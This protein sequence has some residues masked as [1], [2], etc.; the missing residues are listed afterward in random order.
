MKKAGQSVLWLGVDK[1]IQM[2]T[3][4]IAV[5]HMIVSALSFHYW[6]EMT[7]WS[8]CQKTNTYTILNVTRKRSFIDSKNPMSSTKLNLL[9]IQGVRYFIGQESSVIS[10][11]LVL[12]LLLVM[13]VSINPLWGSEQV[14]LLPDCKLKVHLLKSKKPSELFGAFV[15]AMCLAA[16]LELKTLFPSTEGFTEV[17]GDIFLRG[18]KKS[19]THSMKKCLTTEFFDQVT[20]QFLFHPSEGSGIKSKWSWCRGLS[21]G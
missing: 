4:G 19:F 6:L 12:Y 10:G 18:R 7:H 17:L 2:H 14:E 8:W 15:L 20:L 3:R 9:V 16:L 5:F 1:N 13:N 11:P 21:R